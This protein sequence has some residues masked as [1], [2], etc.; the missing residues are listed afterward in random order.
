MLELTRT[1]RFNLTGDPADLESPRH[2]TFAGWPAARGLG[3]YFELSVVCRGTADPQTGYFINIKQIDTAVRDHALPRLNARLAEPRAAC[4]TPMGTLMHDLLVAL[5]PDLRDSVAMIELALS[6]FSALAIRSNNMHRVQLKQQYE[7]SAA[8]RLHVPG[9]SDEE[10]RAIFGKCNNP[11]GHGHNYRVQVV[12]DAD[13]DADGRTLGSATLDAAVDRH[14]I[15]RL[16]HKHL[17]LD[18]PEFADL[19]PSVEHIAQVVWQM[20]VD[21]MPDAANLAEISVWETGKT[22]CTYRGQPAKA[23][24]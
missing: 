6:P 21:Q 19:N 22:V 15:Q 16:D 18:V 12:V 3:R 17:N 10:N 14:C 4:E 8:H 5:Q 9:K 24:V 7:F 11:A 13:I 20:L 1:V 2:N 23:S